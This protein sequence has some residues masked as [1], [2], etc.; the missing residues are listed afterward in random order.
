MIGRLILIAIILLSLQ[1]NAQDSYS[2][3]NRKINYDSI[4]NIRKQKRRKLIT[5]VWPIFYYSTSYH[6]ILRRPRKR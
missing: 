2:A 1:L 3:F 5:Y 6:G 4:K